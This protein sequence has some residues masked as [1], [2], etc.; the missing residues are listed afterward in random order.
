MRLWCFFCC[1]WHPIIKENNTRLMQQEELRSAKLFGHRTPRHAAES[2]NLTRR[3]WTFTTSRLRIKPPPHNPVG[4][5]SSAALAWSPRCVSSASTNCFCGR[6]AK[7]ERNIWPSSAFFSP[8]QDKSSGPQLQQ[9]LF[10]REFVASCMSICAIQAVGLVHQ[11][12]LQ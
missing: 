3:Y 1:G 5:R 12:C 11:I 4:C 6:G 8:K 2:S 9:S 10:K 7:W